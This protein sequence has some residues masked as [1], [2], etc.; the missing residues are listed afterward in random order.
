MRTIWFG[1]QAMARAATL[2]DDGIAA[3]EDAAGVRAILAGWGLP[4]LSAGV[5][6]AG[7]SR[8]G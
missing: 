7:A 6:C 5:A 1:P 2:D 3:A 8:H 4:A